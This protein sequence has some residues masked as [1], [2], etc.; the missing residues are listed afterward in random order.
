[1]LS[2]PV[3]RKLAPVSVAILACAATLGGCNVSIAPPPEAV[4]AGTWQLQDDGT[5]DLEVFYEFDARG[6]LTEVRYEFEV[7]GRSATRLLE[8]SLNGDDVTIRFES[9][10]ASSEFVGTVNDAVDRME[11]NVTTDVVL[12]LF[13]LITVE[14]DN[15]PATLVRVSG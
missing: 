12:W 2:S 4:L 8:V 14:V 5:D 11:G 1:M 10:W 7:D 3:C 9:A 6:R 15:G 13:P